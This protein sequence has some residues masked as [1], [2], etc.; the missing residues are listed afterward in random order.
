MRKAIND[1]SIPFEPQQ[2]S[3][4]RLLNEIGNA[5]YVLLGESSH[6]TSEFYSIRSEITKRLIEEKGFTVVGI[7]G[8]W[9]SS[10]AVN[11]YVKE[12]NPH[13]CKAKE[14][15]SEFKRW[16]SWMWANEE[17][18][19]LI[20]WMREKNLEK[21][22]H[23]RTGFYGL[24]V[25]SLWE[26][27]EKIYDYIEKTGRGDVEALRKVFEC[28]DPFQ[29]DN[30]KYAISAAVQHE[31][32]LHEVTNLL[33]DVKKNY[34]NKLNLSEENFGAMINAL[35]VSHAEKYYRSMV[36]HNHE[37]WNIRD[38]HMVEALNTI[39]KFHGST[40]KAVIWE[41]NTHVGD[42]RATDMKKDGMVNVGQLLREQES[43]E[44]VYI[45]GF[46]TYSGTVI[47]SESWGN[48]YEVMNVPNAQSGSWEEL[49]HQE[50]AAD[51][52]ILFSSENAD[53]FSN[54][55][56]H[57]AI[58][59][60]YHPEYE[61]HGNYVPSIMSARYDAFIFLNETTHLHPF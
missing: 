57:R 40:A 34:E 44:N 41:H 39:M 55:I 30:E 43:P 1:F 37:S 7:E 32:C 3:I 51:K 11:E 59:V 6:G 18:I 35:V 21:H 45:V 38:R 54:E 5:Q 13:Y 31:S 28:F 50:G 36:F 48:N 17:M 24:D 8:D 22:F 60:V 61:A 23:E 27:L 12:K 15:L 10:Q 46:G 20:E 26:S 56:G 25:Y 49:L 53:K 9:P 33:V 19:S 14:A 29:Q 2:D 16:P 52:M 47:A 4:T 42:A 58:G